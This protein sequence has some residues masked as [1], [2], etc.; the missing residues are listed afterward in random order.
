MATVLVTGAGGASGIGAIQS[1]TDKNDHQVIGVD[2]DPTAAGLYLADAG[3]PIPP[4]DD[5]TWAEKMAQIVEEFG[6]EVIIPTVDEELTVLQSLSQAVGEV[7]IVAPKQDVIEIARD[8]YRTMQELSKAGVPTPKTWLGTDTDQIPNTAFPLIVKPRA[9]RGSRGVQRVETPTEL[10]THL[11]TTTIDAERLLCQEC[12][13]G[14]EYTTSVVGTNCNR[15]L[16]VVPKEALKKEGSTVL[17]ATRQMPAV[18]EICRQ[19]FETLQ[20]AGPLNVQQLLD[21]DGIPRVIEINPR[22]SSTSCLTV[23]A[24]VN[25]FDLLVRDALGQQVDPPA[26][27]ETDHYIIRYQNH[28][29]ADGIDHTDSS[30]SDSASNLLIDD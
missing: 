27:F 5:P 21:E 7:P 17:G 20:P 14:P 19:I 30:S 23:A 28:L 13:S 4:A 10:A 16:S 25:E 11:K 9:G 3:S 29:F 8:K 15:L 6:V 12:L 2:M 26:G 24:G 22:F 18:D 1:L